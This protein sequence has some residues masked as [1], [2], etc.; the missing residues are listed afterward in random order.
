MNSDIALELLVRMDIETLRKVS[1]IP[2]FWL[3]LRPLLLSQQFW[4]RRACHLV[5][6]RELQFR[7]GCWGQTYIELEASL[8]E[9]NPLFHSVNLKYSL[10]TVQVLLELGF[11]PLKDCGTVIVTAMTQHLEA[12]T[13]IIPFLT[14]EGILIA[15]SLIL[16][17]CKSRALRLPLPELDVLLR[18]GLY[19]VLSPE[20]RH[21]IIARLSQ[22]LT[23]LT[24]AVRDGLFGIVKR[25][26][27][28]SSITPYVFNLRDAVSGGHTDVVRILLAD[29]RID[30]REDSFGLAHLI[31]Q[32]SLEILHLFQ[33]D[34]RLWS[35]YLDMA[36]REAA[37]CGNLPVFKELLSLSHNHPVG[38]LH[39]LVTRPSICERFAT[40]IPEVRSAV[41][42]ALLSYSDVTMFTL[43]ICESVIALVEPLISCRLVGAY[44]ANFNPVARGS[45]T[46]YTEFIRTLILKR[47]TPNEALD[48]LSVR[49]SRDAKIA[50]AS[51]A[52]ELEYAPLTKTGE[53]FRGYFLAITY[54]Y[55]LA[56]AAQ[57]LH[58]E[59]RSRDGIK[60][61]ARLVGA[62]LGISDIPTWREYRVAFQAVFGY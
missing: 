32:R 14:E 34:G 37:C 61:A 26:L 11:S 31:G 7:D 42:T 60:L 8:T 47:L 62:Q 20:D 30:P 21:L 24:D 12:L 5:G 38:L 53:A 33:E 51:I 50:A 13:V 57:V 41:V 28:L 58:N 25:C 10:L 15:W 16:P 44:R 40:V 46:L 27:Q 23:T 43:S 19:D 56:E 35:G 2:D 22:R 45:R 39:E 54:G 49:D 52:T 1:L 59:N 4:H 18:I 48:W 3:C 9:S 17:L 36:I 6:D 29:G 55:D